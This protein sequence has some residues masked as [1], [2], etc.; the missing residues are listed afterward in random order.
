MAE[1]DLR[2]GDRQ[3]LQL[4]DLV[5]DLSDRPVLVG[6]EVPPAGASADLL[7][8]APA[9]EDAGGAVRADLGRREDDLPVQA[10]GRLQQRVVVGDRGVG[11]G[12]ARAAR[13]LPLR[14]L[15]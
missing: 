4:L 1:R 15:D 13:R 9:A 5:A 11:A 7:E 3:A 10:R 8:D 12:L 14:E 6:L 2:R